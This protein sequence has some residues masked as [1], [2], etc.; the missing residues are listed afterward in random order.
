MPP[1]PAVSA[2]CFSTSRYPPGDDRPVPVFD[3]SFLTG[4]LSRSTVQSIPKYGLPRF[5]P[6]LIPSQE[7]RIMK[8]HATTSSPLLTLPL[9]YSFNSDL[10][11]DPE[12]PWCIY[13][14]WL[15]SIGRKLEW[16]TLTGESSENT[17][18]LDLWPRLSL[19]L[20]SHQR[21]LS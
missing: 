7:V 11:P 12:T 13:R 16:R 14:N 20:F 8:G 17:F 10:R 4:V 1:F 19:N 15:N 21:V 2:M 9:R 5:N 3:F 6:K 18:T